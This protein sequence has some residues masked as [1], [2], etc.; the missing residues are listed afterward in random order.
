[1]AEITTTN[2]P[3]RVGV[4]GLGGMGVQH[5]RSVDSLGHRVVGGADVD[6]GKREAFSEAFGARTYETHEALYEGEALDAVL[7]ATPNKFHEPTAVAAL[8][9]GV[10]VLIEKPLAHTLESAERIARAEQAA[11]GFGMV[12]FHNRFSPAT[13]VFKE[14][15]AN[16]AFGDVTH[17]QVH[18]VRRRGIPG[19]NSWFT[20]PELAG[21]GALIDIGV[22]AIDLA[23]YVLGFPRVVEATGISRS[24]FGWRSKYVDPDRPESNDLDGNE[25]SFEVDDSA[26]AFIRTADDRTVS[27]E[28]AWAASQTPRNDVIVRGTDGGAA[29][30]LGGDSLT[31]HH[32]STRGTPHYRTS[33]ITAT[34]HR[35]PHET[36]LEMFLESVV[37]REPP[38]CNTFDQG[39]V[40]Q[41][42][43]DAVYRSAEA[44]YS[45]SLARTDEEVPA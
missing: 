29:F 3:V 34:P 10:D 33:E 17:V 16:G 32:T 21:G 12:G 15:Q 14:Y 41:N 6:P 13:T 35:T 2:E 45:I 31:I 39:L 37:T 25:T 11:E 24:E 19:R 38:A 7:V 9:R 30:E 1:M 42:V 44:G 28:V 36:Q 43:V 22:H 20:D 26:S 23:L 18:T 5:A 4:V 27:V 40:V 8:E